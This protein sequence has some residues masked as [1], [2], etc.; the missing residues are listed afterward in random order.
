MSFRRAA[1]AAR[2]GIFR[3]P[4]R[5][6]LVLSFSAMA[7][8]S[9]SC[10][11]SAK[12]DATHQAYLTLPQKGNVA[13]L[14]INDSSGAISVVSQTAPV[15]GTSPNG[16][17]LDPG[18]KFL[19]VSNGSPA[20]SVSVY[21]IG[22]DG[23]LTQN[24]NALP[25]GS[26]PRFMVVDPSGKY[27]LITNSFDNNVSVYSLGSGTLTLVGNAPADKNPNELVF[28]PSG[29]FVYVSNSTGFISAYAFNSGNGNMTPVP[30]SPFPS[31]GGLAGL[32]IDQTKHYLF[33]ANATDNTVSVFT[34][35]SGT[36][37][38]HRIS[39]SPFPA[40]TG[41]RALTMDTTNAFLYVANQGSDNVSAFSLDPA[42][43]TLI[44]ITG[45]PFSAGTEPIF[46]VAEPAGGFIY[47]GNQKGTNITSFSYDATGKLTAVS[48]SPFTVPS[49]PG[50]LVIVH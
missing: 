31:G 50:A 16:V 49:A 13:L 17:A 30:G 44:P 48:G 2:A 39:G 35:D 8:L 40:G 1:D 18:K 29:E 3:V 26:G 47:V 22:G 37:V 4:R 32:A 21:N 33:A 6:L 42:T 20:N 36:G 9:V 46:I 5:L 41:P 24:G 12:S 45:S 10:G 23:T 43:G 15:V 28:F 27:L 11:G 7:A 38:L 14:H 25:V 19:Y 34:I